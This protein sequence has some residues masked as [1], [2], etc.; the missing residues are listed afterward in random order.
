MVFS[1]NPR[2]GAL[3]FDGEFRR[4]LGRTACAAGLRLAFPALI[5]A[6]GRASDAALLVQSSAVGRHPAEATGVLLL[7]SASNVSGSRPRHCSR[8]RAFS[9]FVR[10][11]PDRAAASG[12]RNVFP[13]LLPANGWSAVPV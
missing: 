6:G 11:S 3:I 2:T 1:R 8:P 5:S 12:V 13:L 9:T 7:L 10:R 4:R